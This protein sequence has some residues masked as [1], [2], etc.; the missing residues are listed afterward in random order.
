M[1][2]RVGCPF[3]SQAQWFAAWL[4]AFA[5][6][7][8]VEARI[9]GVALPF[10]VRSQRRFGWSFTTLQAPVNDHSPCLRL[11]CVP[12]M[13]GTALDV[14]LRDLHRRHSFAWI[15]LPLMEADAPEAV[16]L[17]ELAR[18]GWPVV[19]ESHPCT[20]LADLSQGWET[21]HSALSKKL[22]ANTNR[23][24]NG[25]RR[26]GDVSFSTIM[27]KEDWRAVWDEFLRL[28]AA[29]W[30]GRAGGAIVARGETEAFYRRVLAEAARQGRLR[31]Y[32]L[33]LNGRLIG[34][35]LVMLDGSTAYG[36]KTAYAPDLAKFS[37][38]NVL[39][40]HVTRA[41]AEEDGIRTLDMLDPVTEWKRRWATTIRPRCHLRLFSPDWKGWLLWRIARRRVE[42]EVR[43]EGSP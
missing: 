24:E 42:M 5:E 8:V 13:D 6:G 2:E 27:G 1:T 34:A 25:L 33:R 40:R 20:A 35:N 32:A 29:G 12:G 23:A 19:E 43:K 21:Y 31:L 28:E 14:A 3:F 41:L 10:L 26:L 9:Q 39:Q 17:R 7:E 36:W 15:E 38:G 16:H 11:P 4:A 30:K 22:R 37:P 18:R